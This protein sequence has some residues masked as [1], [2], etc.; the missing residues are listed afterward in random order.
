MRKRKP[1]QSTRQS[2]H[3]VG[4]GQTELFY[5]KHLKRIKS[6]KC[7]ISPRLKYIPNFGKDRKFLENEKWVADMT[8]GGKLELACE[9][10]ERYDGRESYSNLHKTIT[11]L[12][13]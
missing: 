7:N 12:N 4:E 13:E 3:I 5:F 2:I 8:S 11:K 6:Y 1:T 9:R 10:A